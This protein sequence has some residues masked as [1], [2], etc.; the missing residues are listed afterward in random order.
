MKTRGT[1][2]IYHFFRFL[3]MGSKKEAALTASGRWAPQLFSS[4]I[5]SPHVIIAEAILSAG[6]RPAT[7]RTKPTALDILGSFHVSHIEKPSPTSE[8]TTPAV[9]GNYAPAK[10]SAVPSSGANHLYCYIT[11]SSFRCIQKD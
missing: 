8:A 4:A 5:A 3:A 1:F 2:S 10:A 11:V 7:D 6:N 9:P